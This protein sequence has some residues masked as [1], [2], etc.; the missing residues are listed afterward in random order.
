MT[1]LLKN[2]FFRNII[3]ISFYCVPYIIAFFFLLFYGLP[4]DNEGIITPVIQT[5]TIE[6]T[7]TS[8]TLG[9]LFS[10]QDNLINE[11]KEMVIWQRKI[12]YLENE[13]KMMAKIACDF[14]DY[15]PSEISQI[16]LENVQTQQVELNNKKENVEHNFS[17]VEDMIKKLNEETM[18]FDEVLRCLVT[19]AFYG[20][21]ASVIFLGFFGGFIPPG[22]GGGAAARRSLATPGSSVNT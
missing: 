7:N 14:N 21:V 3:N 17:L 9:F 1:K 18:T 6:T 16:I 4:T 13:A 19:G 11:V 20:L 5:L 10:I 8:C 15:I 22:G 2:N 12:F